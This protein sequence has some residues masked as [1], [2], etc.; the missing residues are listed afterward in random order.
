MLISLLKIPYTH[1]NYVCL[2]LANPICLFN[3]V[4]KVAIIAMH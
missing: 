2:V 4:Q 3:L 1:R